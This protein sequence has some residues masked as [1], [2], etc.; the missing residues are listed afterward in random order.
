MLSKGIS[1]YKSGR[2]SKVITF[3][4]KKSKPLK[5]DRVFEF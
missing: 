3:K 1:F 4:F 2:H 5:N